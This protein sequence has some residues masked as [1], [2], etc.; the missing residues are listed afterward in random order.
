MHAVCVGEACPIGTSLFR[1]FSKLLDVS[2]FCKLSTVVPKAPAASA[3]FTLTSAEALVGS[4]YGA[5]AING[6]AHSTYHLTAVVR[7]IG[8]PDSGHY[9][10][11]RRVASNLPKDAYGQPMVPFH[12][13]DSLASLASAESASVTSGSATGS[14]AADVVDSP[15]SDAGSSS[16]SAPSRPAHTTPSHWVRISDSTVEPADESE[17]LE[18]EAYMLYY[19]RGDVD[20]ADPTALTVPSWRDEPTQFWY[21]LSC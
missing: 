18:C 6:R 9:V 8:G 20:R 12:C 4:A 16:A 10:T 19:V 5:N 14:G 7:H 15:K 11:Y 13:S 2:D 17:V 21:P 3:T 1:S